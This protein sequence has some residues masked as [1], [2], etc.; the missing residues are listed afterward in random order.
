MARPATLPMT[1]PTI[2][3]VAASAGDPDPEV[4]GGRLVDGAA[5][6][7]VSVPVPV[8]GSPKSPDVLVKVECDESVEEVVLEFEEVEVKAALKAELVLV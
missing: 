7:P 5:P 4:G 2:F 1:P 8:P 3:G 6:L